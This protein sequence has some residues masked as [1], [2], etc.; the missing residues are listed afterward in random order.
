MA[1]VQA[2]TGKDR[3]AGWSLVVAYRDTAAPV[4]NLSVFDGFDTVSSSRPQV[5]VKVEGF[6]TPKIGSV[7]SDVGFVAYEGDRGSD[8]RRRDPERDG[9]RGHAQ[10]LQQRLQQHD[11][12]GR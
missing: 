5:D 3:Y 4:R 2:G 10:A 9:A 11:L 1:D 7:R 8:R 6:R 12:A